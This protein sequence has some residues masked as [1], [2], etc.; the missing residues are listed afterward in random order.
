MTDTKKTLLVIGASSDMGMELIRYCSEDYDEIYGLYR[1]MSEDL[2]NLKMVMEKKLS[3]FQCDFSSYE[4]TEQLINDLVEKN[5]IPNH[6]VHFS[7]PRCKNQHFHKIKWETF[8][9]DINIS[10]RSVDMILAR[11]LPYMKKEKY[12]RIVIMLSNVVNNNPPS[13]IANYVTIKYALLGL[14]KS[15]AVEYGKH[16]I[17]I[18][19]ISPAW[20][21]TKFLS[22]QPRIL[23]DSFVEESQIGRY[24]NPMDVV[25]TIKYLLSDEASCINGQNL[26]IA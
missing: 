9:Q 26:T 7:A 23:L 10:L 21:E 6:I 19:G 25:P 13:S 11:F 1:N 17:S 5:C 15:L 12:G 20:V 24:L 2:Q 3:L 14:I 4:A 16:G 22:E 18:N 8:E